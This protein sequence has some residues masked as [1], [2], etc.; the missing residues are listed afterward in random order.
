MDEQGQNSTAAL[1][2]LESLLSH[3]RDGKSLP[4]S[5]LNEARWDGWGYTDT[6]IFINA[7]GQVEFAG[8]RYEEVF[9]AARVLPSLRTW[10]ETKVGLDVN[11]E[12]PRN[13]VPP[14]IKEGGE[15]MNVGFLEAMVALKIPV[16]LDAV[17]RVRHS[18]GQ[19]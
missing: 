18:H 14:S 9:P 15:V 4:T 10:A 6:S 3:L 8:Q 13:A 19:T 1:H 7:D 5:S 17:T 12:A 16:N 11:R 2:R